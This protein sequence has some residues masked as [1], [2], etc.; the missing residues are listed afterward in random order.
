MGWKVKDARAGDVVYSGNDR[1]IAKCD[2]CMDGY[3]N[4]CVDVRFFRDD[5]CVRDFTFDC[6]C[7]SDSFTERNKR[8]NA[9][10]QRFPSGQD[11]LLK[12]MEGL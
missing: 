9:F 10:F 3:G 8:K 6:N 11:R 5:Y 12:K 4:W 2:G 7:Y 1:G